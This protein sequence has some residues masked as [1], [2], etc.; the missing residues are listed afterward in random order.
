METIALPAGAA[1][2]HHAVDGGDES[3]TWRGQQEPAALQGGHAR[4]TMAGRG[5]NPGREMYSYSSQM[6][7]QRRS[8]GRNQGQHSPVIAR[9]GRSG[10]AGLRSSW[11]VKLQDQDLY[12][13]FMVK[14]M[15][16]AAQERAKK[17]GQ[18]LIKPPGDAGE[19]LTAFS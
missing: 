8:G 9:A 19:P 3:L 13:R 2:A 17:G 18:S 16:T 10:E 4:G 14:H 12:Q 1:P 11:E 15:A 6:T 7:E 5:R